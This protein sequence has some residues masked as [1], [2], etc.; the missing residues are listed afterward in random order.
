MKRCPNR[1]SNQLNPPSTTPLS[2]SSTFLCPPYSSPTII[3]LSTP[4]PTLVSGP[5]TE[6]L[7]GLLRK[8]RETE[9]RGDVQNI[10]LRGLLV[11]GKCDTGVTTREGLSTR[12]GVVNNTWDEYASGG[13]G[14]EVYYLERGN[15]YRSVMDVTW[16]G[17][18]GRGEGGE[19]GEEGIGLRDMGEE[20]RIG[21]GVKEVIKKGGRG[22]IE[23]YVKRRDGSVE[24]VPN[25]EIRKHLPA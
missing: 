13:D 4:T 10:E 23:A 21:W 3:A 20:E 12:E 2:I 25:E 22:R 6:G 1:Y 7:W 15:A 8:V 9:V 18:G 24:I 17:H 14:L 16:F 5:L 19:R 11:S